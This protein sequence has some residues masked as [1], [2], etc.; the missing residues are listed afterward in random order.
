MA[1]GLYPND[2]TLGFT[3]TEFDKPRLIR[4]NIQVEQG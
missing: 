2:L 3:V 1:L 4:K